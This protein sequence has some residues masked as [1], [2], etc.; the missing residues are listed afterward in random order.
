MP[1]S[2]HRRRSRAGFSLLELLVA[3][4][5]LGIGLSAAVAFASTQLQLVR[6]NHLRVEVRH[7]LRASGDAIVRDLRLAAACLPQTGAFVS[8]AGTDN[9]TADSLTIRTGFAQ[10][11]L[12]CVATTNNALHGMG[13]STFTVDTTDGFEEA[14]LGY[15]RHLDGDGEFFTITSVDSLTHTITRGEPASRDYPVGSGVFAVDERTYAL[16]TGSTPPRLTLEMGQNGPVPFAIGITE[17]QVQYILD[18]NCT[19]C[20]VVDMPVDDVE[21]WRVNQVSVTLT[22]ET[23]NPRRSEDYYSE[24]RT[25]VGKPRNLLP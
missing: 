16:D 15:L 10:D 7:A 13:S 20:D 9:G 8:L 22:G 5:M 11:N 19:P 2:A 18:R 21:W 17:F 12:A 24:T 1:R 14:S 6:Q 4:G 3:I 25:V 23:V